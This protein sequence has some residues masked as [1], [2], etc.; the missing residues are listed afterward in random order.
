M[1]EGSITT[2]LFD[3]PGPPPTWLRAS[4]SSTRPAG[5]ARLDHVAG[6]PGARTTDAV[7]RFALRDRALGDRRHASQLS[8]ALISDSSLPQLGPARA[9]AGPPAR[10]GGAGG[11]AEQRE[12]TRA[13]A[14]ARNRGLA[15]RDHQVADITTAARFRG[16]SA[17]PAWSGPRPHRGRL[18]DQRRPRRGK[19]YRAAWPPASTQKPRRNEYVREAPPTRP[20]PR[21]SPSGPAS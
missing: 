3:R 7:E 6:R 21:S 8:R 14:P 11:F 18:D 17:A 4:R 13:G 20:R 15:D 2:W 12:R 10:L 19:E 5:P 16:R 9:S 1:I